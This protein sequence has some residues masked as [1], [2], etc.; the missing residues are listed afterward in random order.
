M[1][2]D[3]VESEWKKFKP[4]GRYKRPSIPILICNNQYFFVADD[5]EQIFTLCANR[6][7]VY[8]LAKNYIKKTKI[9][10][11][12]YYTCN[13]PNNLKIFSCTNYITDNK[14]INFINNNI[15]PKI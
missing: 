10:N 2:V 14:L 8:L 4:S 1:L 11:K 7:R 3:I 12:D 5:S 13:N 15:I 6:N 9:K